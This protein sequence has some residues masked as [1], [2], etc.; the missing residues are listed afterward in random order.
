M[1][2]TFSFVFSDKQAHMVL[3]QQD[4]FPVPWKIFTP[5]SLRHSVAVVFLPP[6]CFTHKNLLNIVFSFIPKCSKF[7]FAP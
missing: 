2:H 1:A 4:N 7:Q 5:G 6:Q 3:K